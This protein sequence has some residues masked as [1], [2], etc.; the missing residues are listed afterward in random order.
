M[1]VTPFTVE[2]EPLPTVVRVTPWDDPV[3]DRRGHDPRSAYVE[4]FWLSVLGPTATWLLRRLVAGFDAQPD[5]YELDVT[6]TARSLGLSVTKGMG[7]PFAKALQRCVMFGVAQRLSESWVVRRRVP[8]ISQ[9]HLLRLPAELQSAHEQWAN[10]DDP[11]R[12]PVAGPRPRRGDAR[13]R[14]RP[15]PPRTAARRRRRPGAGRG[16]GVRAAQA[17]GAGLNPSA[18]SISRRV[19]NPVAP[20]ERHDSSASTFIGPAMSRCAH[21]SVADEL[22]QEHGGG[23]RPAVGTA[24]VLDVGD[25]GVEQLAVALGLQRQLPHRLVGGVRRRGHLVDPRLVG[26]RA[27]RRPPGR[28]RPG[29]RRS[30]W[31][32]R[33]WRRAAPRWRATARRPAG[34]GPRRRCC[35]SPRSSRRGSSARRRASSP[36]PTACCPCTAGSPVTAVRQPSAASADID[37]STAAAP[38]MSIFIAACIGSLGLRLMPPESYITPLPTIAR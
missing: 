32:C 29:R 11:P 8:P 25:V 6:G 18:S 1:S 22:G 4:Q 20:F 26:C 5:G 10:D 34:G 33:R 23:D 37:A 28:G 12:R 38:D 3:V 21:G 14:R 16:R 35:G 13:G 7:S 15:G 36:S 19:P 17:A 24:D 2:F 31:R 9:R 30:A 27:R